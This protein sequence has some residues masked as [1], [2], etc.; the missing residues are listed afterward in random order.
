MI[1][2][3][4]LFCSLIINSPTVPISE[5]YVSQ[6]TYDVFVAHNHLDGKYFSE[7]EIGDML[8]YYSDEWNDYKVT[9]IR[10]MQAIT[11]ALFLE[12]D[13]Y[14]TVPQIYQKI[15]SRDLVLQTCIYK[16]GDPAWGRLFVIAEEQ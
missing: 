16:D 13:T 9:D 6:F 7:I 14:Y 2:V 4:F 11:P 1:C 12:G 10:K 15:Y 3:F 5:G 8:R